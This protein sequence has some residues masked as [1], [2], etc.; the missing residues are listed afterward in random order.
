[1]K[2]FGD[3]NRG[4]HCILT[5]IDVFSKFASAIPVHRKSGDFT[6]NAFK[7]ILRISKRKPMRIQFYKGTEF[8]NKNSNHSF[9]NKK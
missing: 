2:K 9:I 6:T 3:K 8:L 1:M 5:V 7:S 4:N